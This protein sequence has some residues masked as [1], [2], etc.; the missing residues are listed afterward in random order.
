M[1]FAYSWRPKKENIRATASPGQR[2]KFSDDSRIDTRLHRE[3][4]LL[5]SAFAREM[6][7][8]N[9]NPYS[10]FLSTTNFTTKD[11]LQ[12]FSGIHSAVCSFTDNFLNV[13][14]AESQ[15][16]PVSYSNKIVVRC[17]YHDPPV[18]FAYSSSERDRLFCPHVS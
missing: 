11:K 1:C 7:C 4:K 6:G 13:I 14:S 9:P 5:K 16:Q 18:T 3:V 10:V 15:I 8:H 2:F 17:H 12:Y